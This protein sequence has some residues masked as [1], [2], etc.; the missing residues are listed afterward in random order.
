MNATV[1]L[2]ACLTVILTGAAGVMRMVWKL[3]QSVRDNTEAV[4]RL[5]TKMDGLNVELIEQRTQ[6]REQAQELTDHRRRLSLIQRA[7]PG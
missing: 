5:S 2:L 4:H 6:L 7:L 1:S 3:V